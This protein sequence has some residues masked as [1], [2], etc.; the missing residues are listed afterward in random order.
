[1]LSVTPNVRFVGVEDDNLD[2]FEGQYPLQKGISYNSYVIDDEKIAVVD[3]VDR[4]RCREW[5]AKLEAALNGR[6][7]DYLI[8]QH[9]EPDHSGSIR[10]MLEKYPS[11]K[12]VATAKALEMLG[13]F[14]ERMDVAERCMAVC[15]NDTL[16]LGRVSL[17]FFT[18][19]MVHWPEVMMTLDE[20]DG[21]LFSADAFGSFATYS[22]AQAWDDEARR[23]YCNIVGKYGSSVQAVMKKLAGRNF[24]IIAP[25][26]GPVLCGDLAGY[27]MLYDKWSRYVP[28][29]DGVLVA[30]ASIYGGTAEAAM[31]LAAMLE[32]NHAGE[33]V[34]M[35]LNRHDVSYA[36]AEAFRLSRMALCCATYDGGLF[37]SMHNFLHH[38]AMKNFR[39][40]PVALVENGSW[41]PMAGKL[42]GDMLGKMKDMPPV[43]PAVTI[44]SRMHA[45]DI[46]ALRCLAEALAKA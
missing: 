32:E 12:I 6:T 37:P 26:H 10:L 14:F 19:P 28:E 23:Y 27:W 45:G 7:P 41:A 17:R 36:V 3:S 25:L 5:L 8:V 24:R 22:A 4:R 31:R 29:T 16:E 11:V 18:A 35:D 34:L 43:A 33:V 38:L 40:R 30:Y 1:M 2:L 44:R 42:M 9:M 21:V 20:T 39:N 13:C 15:D 46:P